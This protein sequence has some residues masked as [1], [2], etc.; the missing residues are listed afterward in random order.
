MSDPIPISS[1]KRIALDYGYDQ[2]LIL[3]V[4]R[5]A[6]KNHITTYG[7]DKWHCDDVAAA[8]VLV[9]RMFGPEGLAELRRIREALD[10]QIAK[11]EQPQ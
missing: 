10:A 4:D 3:G 5:T 1:A 9:G 8:G 7:K 11:L 6:R 2:V